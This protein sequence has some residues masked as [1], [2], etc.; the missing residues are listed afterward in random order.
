MR[1]LFNFLATLI[2][3]PAALS[4]QDI[5]FIRG[6]SG[7]GG[8][9][10]GGADEQLSDITDYSTSAGNHGWGELADLLTA[11][12]YSLSQHIEGPA[13]SPGPVDLVS[14][15]DGGA[16]VIVFVSN[17]AA[18]PPAAVE[19][20][21]EFIEGGGGALFISDANWGSYWSD[22]SDSDQ[23]FVEPFGL[24]M[25][26]DAGTYTLSR[27]NGDFHFPS[28]PIL[29]DLDEFDGEGVTPVTVLPGDVPSTVTV[30]VLASAKGSLRLNDSTGTEAGSLRASEESD[31]VLIAIEAGAGRI[32]CHFDRNTFFNQNGAGTNINRFDNSQ[33]AKN[34]F[35][36]LAAEESHAASWY[37]FAD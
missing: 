34:I 12:G 13:S 10:E 19:R 21:V 23:P 31:G 3:I 7:T 22:A 15:I 14:I 11:Q 35:D 26:Q 28:H 18:Y 1:F 4:A 27:A 9:L 33:L 30:N 8:F 24:L 32:V 16:Y 2:F 6:G 29:E 17:N 25:N 5:A 36:W 20:F 37:H